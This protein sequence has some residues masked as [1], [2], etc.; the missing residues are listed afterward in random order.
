[1]FKQAMN[2][3][4]SGKIGLY[5]TSSGEMT[6]VLLG[7]ISANVYDTTTGGLVYD[8]HYGFTN[9]ISAVI[10]VADGSYTQEYM[11]DFPA[12]YN[13][14]DKLLHL[15][16][17]AIFF[18]APGVSQ[19]AGGI[20]DLDALTTETVIGYVFGGIAADKP[21]FGQTVAS[22]LIFEVTFSPTVG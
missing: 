15:G 10:R 22:P 18:A 16:A 8:K 21:N 17:E 14:S 12:V 5:S 20:L 6:E 4:E 9:Q 7:G 13:A 3:Y 2:H 1:V 19:V 11:G